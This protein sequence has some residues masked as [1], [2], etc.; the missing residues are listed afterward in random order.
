[1][2]DCEPEKLR[3]K[4]RFWPGGFGKQDDERCFWYVL[5]LPSWT[6]HCLRWL[7]KTKAPNRFL[8]ICF[9]CFSC[10]RTSYIECFGFV[11]G[12]ASK[13]LLTGFGWLAVTETSTRES[14]FSG[15]KKPLS[16]SNLS[17]GSS[18][19]FL[20][21]LDQHDSLLT[22]GILQ[23]SLFWNQRS[24]NV[25][26]SR[27]TQEKASRFFNFCHLLKALKNSFFR[28]V[29]ALKDGFSHLVK[30]C[31]GLASPFLGIYIFFGEKGV[32]DL[33]LSC[34]HCLQRNA[35]LGILILRSD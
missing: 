5:L 22:F 18:K 6:F 23:G 14:L 25:R 8:C 24:D 16:P 1:M 20:T 7:L 31:E 26:Q 33:N 3:F 19:V 28:L 9:C 10:F 4:C 27:E 35:L 17:H 11:G 13:V 30:H 34:L 2:N 12:K 15:S 29:K 21:P 32:E